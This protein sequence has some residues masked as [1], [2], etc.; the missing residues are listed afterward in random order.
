MARGHKKA[1]F[2]FP[3]L[4]PSPPFGG[5]LP[6]HPTDCKSW[7]LCMGT[8]VLILL[9][10]SWTPNCLPVCHWTFM[11]QPH[12]PWHSWHSPA[13]LVAGDYP[14][15]LWLACSPASRPVIPETKPRPAKTNVRSLSHPLCHQGSTAD[16][17]TN[18]CV[19]ETCNLAK[20][21]SYSSMCS[22]LPPTDLA[23]AGHGDQEGGWGCDALLFNEARQNP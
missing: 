17:L 19:M 11:V 13:T 9:L 3:C 5:L 20:L 12:A 4:A 23:S 1:M 22:L 15:A 7:H 10:K 6:A 14:V 18:P 2:V 8:T 16:S 21:L